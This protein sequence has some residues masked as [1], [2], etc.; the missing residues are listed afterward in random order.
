MIL[1]F[2]L[3]MSDFEIIEIGENVVVLDNKYDSNITCIELNDSIIFADTGSRDDIASKFRIDMEKKFNKKTS[4]LFLTHYHWDHIGG[5]NSFK[6]VEI[7]GSESGLERYKQDLDGS[8]SKENRFAEVER[9]KEYIARGIGEENEF[10]NIFHEYFPKMEL[11]LPSLSVKDELVIGSGKRKV[12]FKVIGGH[13]QCSA[14]VFVPFAKTLIFGDNLASDTSQQGQCFFNGLDTNITKLYNEIEQLNFDTVIPGHGKVVDRKYFVNARKFFE[15]LFLALGKLTLKQ[16]KPSDLKSD[17]PELPVHFA[18]D[19]SDSWHL[20]LKRLYVSISTE[21]IGKEVDK[22]KELF[23]QAIKKGNKD[24][25]V[26][27]R[28]NDLEDMFPNGRFIQGIDDYNQQVFFNPIYQGRYETTERYFFG[29]KFVERCFYYYQ[30]I[31][32]SEEM[33]REYFYHWKLVA[34]N[35]KLYSV[36]RL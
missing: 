15:D 9:N 27:Y 22:I 6:D 14:Y 18:S 11:F 20:I 26:D 19:V 12:I 4:H 30:P 36:I 17:H 21:I 24:V 28:T 10:I 23:V 32:D 5:M 13:S 3:F 16:V 35:W 8:L 33:R 2:H 29:D 7:V 34:N 1:L 25:I 31:A